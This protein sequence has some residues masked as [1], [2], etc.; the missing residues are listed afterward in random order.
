MKM[1]GTV[2]VLI[3][4]SLTST[5]VVAEW[6][7]SLPGHFTLGERMSGNQWIEDLGPEPVLTQF[8]T[9]PVFG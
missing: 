1:Y 8:F 4:V 9:L 3:H 7:D 6:P 2:D 5:L